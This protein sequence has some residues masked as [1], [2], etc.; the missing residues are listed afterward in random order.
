VKV[1]WLIEVVYDAAESRGP[2]YFDG[3]CEPRWMGNTTHRAEVAQTYATKKEAEEDI[4]KLAPRLFG[5]W[6]A[7]EHGFL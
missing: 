1:V 5:E 3:S 2:R 7:V 4:L 6:R